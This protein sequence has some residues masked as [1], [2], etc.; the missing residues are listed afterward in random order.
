MPWLLSQPPD[1]LQIPWLQ[2]AKL[3]RADI[4]MKLNSTQGC[5]I[6]RQEK[7]R[8]LEVKKKKTKKKPYRKKALTKS[9][10]TSA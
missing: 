1:S 6:K 7:V 2:S 8:H 9:T 5:E 10:L 4:C 3:G